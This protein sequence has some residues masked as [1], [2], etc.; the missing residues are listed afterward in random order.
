MKKDGALV[1]QDFLLLKQIGLFENSATY[2]SL[3]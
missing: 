2:F 3:R 1:Q